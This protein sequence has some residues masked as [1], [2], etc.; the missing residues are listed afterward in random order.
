MPSLN[1]LDDIV[2][3]TVEEQR[4]EPQP[5]IDM[6][7]A[8]PMEKPTESTPGQDAQV[9]E[10]NRK[11]EQIDYRLSVIKAD[12]ELM[13]HRL[14]YA[15]EASGIERYR[16]QFVK[17]AGMIDIIFA[18]I[19]QDDLLAISHQLVRDYA[20][21]RWAYDQEMATLTRLYR[22]VC[23]IETI[24]IRNPTKKVE[25]LFM[26]S[27]WEP[28]ATGEDLSPRKLLDK[29]QSDILATNTCM[30]ICRGTFELFEQEL[31]DLGFLLENDPDF[32][33]EG[34]VSNS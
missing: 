10:E 33:Y 6:S 34:L 13:N 27:D 23:S 4:P 20:A 8:V 2:D 22:L 24:T 9:N 32:F 31:D 30:N 26:R 28:P 21:G 14:Q 5:E 15:L 29:L 12:N 19:S 25:K 16:R 3:E 1:P 11:K 7:A 18:T 17:A